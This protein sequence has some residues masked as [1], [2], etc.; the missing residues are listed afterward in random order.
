MCYRTKTKT[1]FSNALARPSPAFAG[2]DL[3]DVSSRP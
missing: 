1:H 3:P 2:L